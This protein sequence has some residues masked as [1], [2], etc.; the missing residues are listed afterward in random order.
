[1]IVTL[2]THQLNSIEKVREFILGTDPVVF[3]FSDRKQAHLW[4]ADTLRRFAYGGRSK[5]HKGLKPYLTGRS[6]P[7]IGNQGHDVDHG[8]HLG[9]SCDLVRSA[10][11]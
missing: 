8:D 2:Q 7:K 5:E 11:K 9:N 3:G 1:M 4:M 6:P 10:L